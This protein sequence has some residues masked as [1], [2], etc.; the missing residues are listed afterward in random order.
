MRIRVFPPLVAV[1]VALG[2]VLAPPLASSAGATPVIYLDEFGTGFLDFGDGLIPTT[3]VLQPDP[4]PGGLA[5]VLTY[6]L[7]GPPALIAGDVQ[8]SDSGLVLDVLRFNPAGTGSAGYPAS[9]LFYSDNVDGFDA[10]ADTPSPP[11]SLYPNTVT[12][13]EVSLAG[14]AFPFFVIPGPEGIDGAQYTPAAGQPGF[15]P[16]FTTSYVFISDGRITTTNPV[17]EPATLS[18]L[19]IGTGVLAFRRRRRS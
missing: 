6:N 16:G 7:L 17:P 19:M 8:L 1:F 14:L 13:P 2:L 12:L 3:G 9:V 5:S 18:L 15:V 11:G 10:P 4:G